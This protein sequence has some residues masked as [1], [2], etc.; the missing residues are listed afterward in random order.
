MHHSKINQSVQT[1]SKIIVS[2]SHY[3]ENNKIW[4]HLVDVQDKLLPLIKLSPHA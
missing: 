1:N 3:L 4:H 2:E